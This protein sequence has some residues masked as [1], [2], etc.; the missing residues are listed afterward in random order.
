MLK[1]YIDE[2]E[3]IKIKRGDKSIQSALE[4]FNCGDPNDPRSC[5]SCKMVERFKK[6]ILEDTSYPKTHDMYYVIREKN[7]D[8][9]MLFFSLQAS[10]IFLTQ[11]ISP[12]DISE[13]K[14]A[15]N[16]A[17]IDD[18]GYDRP[19]DPD[20]LKGQLGVFDNLESYKNKNENEFADFMSQLAKLI[21]CKKQD[22]QNNIYVDRII[23]SI[24]MVNFCKNK[25]A[26]KKWRDLGFLPALGATLFW[27]KV[28][29]IIEKISDT[30]GC[31]YVSIFAADVYS[32]DSDK[33]QN[34]LAYYQSALSFESKQELC[35]LKP[36][37]DWECIFLCQEIGVLSSKKE[38]FES[39]YLSAVSEDDV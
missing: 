6:Y 39:L 28:L 17:N 1:Q 2:L 14:W 7:S 5:V 36:H 15:Y 35:V 21:E 3:C 22:V 8:E 29:P 16:A 4:K 19:L 20:N 13:L 30:I 32:R 25:N 9:I 24:E 31:T 26:D 38:N 18:T 27:Y 34:L 23:P 11:V 12:E 10:Q 37:Y 33:R